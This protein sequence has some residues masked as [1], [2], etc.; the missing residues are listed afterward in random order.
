MIKLVILWCKYQA[1]GFQILGKT[2]E[3]LK[4]AQTVA[5]KI[6]KSANMTNLIMSSVSSTKIALLKQME[7]SLITIFIKFIMGWQKLRI[8]KCTEKF[9]L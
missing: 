3:N 1:Y 8:L 6:S 4:F 5:S 2:S 9:M 7:W